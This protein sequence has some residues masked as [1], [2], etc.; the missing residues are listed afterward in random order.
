MLILFFKKAPPISVTV[1]CSWQ[2]FLFVVCG[3]WFLVGACFAKLQIANCQP[4]YQCIV[5]IHEVTLYWLK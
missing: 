5:M 4:D 3:F 1:P 2:F